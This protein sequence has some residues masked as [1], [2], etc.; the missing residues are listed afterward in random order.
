M[1][2]GGGW[3]V[4]YV[5]NS[6]D[7]DPLPWIQGW[8]HRPGGIRKTRLA[9]AP[10][11]DRARAL[12]GGAGGVALY[13][14]GVVKNLGDGTCFIAVDGGMADNPR[15]ALYRAVYSPLIPGGPRPDAEPV[16]PA[17]VVGKFCERA[18]S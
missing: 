9:A 8:R 10:A 7:D 6:P 5:P 1:S 4:P 14:V 2:P 15:P 18:T 11:G 16:Q 17:A 13:T 12:A 3:G